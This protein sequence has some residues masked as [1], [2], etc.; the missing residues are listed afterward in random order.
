MKMD[1]SITAEQ[2]ASMPVQHRNLYY[3][4]KIIQH[5]PPR[6]PHEIFLL[7]IYRGLLDSPDDLKAFEEIDQE[8]EQIIHHAT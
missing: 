3:R 5:T 2:L 1:F 8:F 4:M 6:N 7:K